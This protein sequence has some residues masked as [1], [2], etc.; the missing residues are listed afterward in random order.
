[1]ANGENAKENEHWEE[2]VGAVP[3][4]AVRP[5][6]ARRRS[7]GGTRLTT[8]GSRVGFHVAVGEPELLPDSTAGPQREAM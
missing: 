2:S 5:F 6:P 1:M 3:D 7:G 4:L 8:M